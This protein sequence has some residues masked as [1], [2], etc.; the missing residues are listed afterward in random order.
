MLWLVIQPIGLLSMQETR[1]KNT[2]LSSVYHIPNT[3][4]LHVVALLKSFARNS[5]WPQDGLCKTHTWYLTLY[6]TVPCN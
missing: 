5:I 6:L 4:K 2:I 1:Y 3:Y